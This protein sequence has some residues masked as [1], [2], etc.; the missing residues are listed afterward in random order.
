MLRHSTVTSEEGKK[1]STNVNYVLTVYMA[2]RKD[3][4]QTQLSSKI[5]DKRM[6]RNGNR[7]KKT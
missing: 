7:M 2:S 6:A 3:F 4:F 5:V 1:A